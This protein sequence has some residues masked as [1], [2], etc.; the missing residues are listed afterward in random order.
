MTDPNAFKIMICSDTH[1]GYKEK[2]PVLIN[3][4]FD[5]FEEV[6]QI[7]NERKVDFLLH[8]GDLFHEHKPSKETF[9]R[10]ED[11]LSRYVFGD[12]RQDYKIA[13][14][15][16]L[17]TRESNLS[18]QL[19]IF[20]IHGNHDDPGG[21][22]N[23]SNVDIVKAAKLV[24]YMG[25][26][27]CLEKIEV[28]PILFQKG[29]TKIA[30]YG[31]GYIKDERLNLAFE[32]K[33]IKFLR[34]QGDWFNILLL[35]QTKE[36]GAGIGLN[37]RQYIREK[38]LPDFFNLIV[39]GHEHECIPI[40]KKCEQTGTNILY[41][42]ST[43]VTSLIDSEAKPKHCFIL[44]LQ[45]TD[46]KLEPIPLKTARPFIYDQIELSQTGIEKD[47]AAVLKYIEEKIDKMIE[48]NIEER[49]ELSSKSKVELPNEMIPLL[50]LKIEYTGY[51]VAN[52]RL[53][54]KKLE[55]KIANWQRDYVKFYKRPIHIPQPVTKNKKGEESKNIEDQNIA[56]LFNS[57]DVKE[58]E[59]PAEKQLDILIDRKLKEKCEDFVIPT[60]KFM[61]VIERST[62]RSDGGH[63]MEGVWRKV[64]TEINKFGSKIICE[65]SKELESFKGMTLEDTYTNVVKNLLNIDMETLQKEIHDEMLLR[66]RDENGKEIKG[67]DNMEDY[68]ESKIQTSQV[69]DMDL[70][71]PG[72]KVG[73]QK[74]K[75]NFGLISKVLP[76]KRKS[77]LIDQNSNGNIKKFKPDDPILEPNNSEKIRVLP[78]FVK[79]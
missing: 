3:D 47:D 34:P 53:L 26:V 60:D 31:I 48:R 69:E 1:L 44:D 14:K 27:E 52:L 29:D 66:P 23:M 67:L 7:A 2:D 30:L 61:E 11:I 21:F 9:I 38:I 6:L 51:S 68:E 76:E 10:T 15:V 18:I 25:K 72:L 77:Y 8:G 57:E 40:L 73:L 13:S 39:W 20:M 64:Y 12:P 22:G 65:N 58:M 74:Q 46:F 36:R 62:K 19:P 24:N 50:R 32:K 54:T 45:K 56:N 41:L 33:Q 55:G 35:H 78:Q 42:G 17:N 43:V 79:K 71:E 63:T 70:G 59:D 49:K 28:E 37:K 16:P 5:S 4:S 75:H